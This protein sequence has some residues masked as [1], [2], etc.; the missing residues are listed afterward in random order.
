MSFVGGFHPLGQG[1]LSRL[2]KLSTLLCLTDTF[3]SLN[4]INA[5]LHI[6]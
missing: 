2:G 3:L 4:S 1:I 6:K 5:L